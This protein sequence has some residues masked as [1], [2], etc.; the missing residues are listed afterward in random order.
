MSA[1]K[2][3]LW[4][5]YGTLLVAQRGDLDSLA[6]R[7]GELSDAFEQTVR[8]FSLSIPSPTLH[9][10]F[11]AAIRTQRETRRSEGAPYPEVRI[12]EIWTRLL[13]EDGPWRAREVALFFERH[14]NPK[15]LQPGAFET[16]TRLKQR[17]LRQG[18]ISNAQFYT[19]IELSELLQEQSVGTDVESI[20]D[21]S[22]IFLSCDLGVAKPDPTAFRQ[23][24]E[25]LA[26]GGTKPAEC[27]FV[28]DSPDHDITPS[29]RAG[30]Q[31]MLFAPDFP[32]VPGVSIQK[33]PALLGLL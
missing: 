17:G 23:A 14:A 18:I 4:D 9:E 6:R 29:R 30:F 7:D 28:G 16:L 12:E 31:A 24:V 10:R 32:P 8:Q 27:L 5:V 22:L 2:A 21:P 11:L 3:V 33:L 19:P 26:R 25:V 15:R 1:Y 13:Q 20:F